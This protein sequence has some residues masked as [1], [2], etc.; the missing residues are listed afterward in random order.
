MTCVCHLKKAVLIDKE[1]NKHY[2]YG[3]LAEVEAFASKVK[4]TS[5]RYINHVAPR[6]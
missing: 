1:N 5:K 2:V 4:A 3:S 6:S